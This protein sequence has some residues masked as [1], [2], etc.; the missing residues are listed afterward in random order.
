[1]LLL[2]GSN[3]GLFNGDISTVSNR[4]L[5]RL[6]LTCFYD[7]SLVANSEYCVYQFF[8]NGSSLRTLYDYMRVTN[9]YKTIAQ[10]CTGFS[11]TI[12]VGFG[13]C[14]PL[15]FELFD[16][17]ILCIC[18]TDMCNKNF[19]S[20]QSSV[21]NQLQINSAPSV[22]SS[23]V[24]ELNTPIS[25]Y[26]SSDS[27]NTSFYCANVASPYIDIQKCNE[28]TMNNTANGTTTPI[29]TGDSVRKNPNNIIV[30]LWLYL[31]I[32]LFSLLNLA[33]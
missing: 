3:E 28:Y 4:T 14:S 25:C 8:S 22:L 17:S 2:I 26:D 10:R 12:D 16:I 30:F 21:T 9:I 5:N 32:K 23:M 6:N 20:C 24:P 15:E 19:T 1:M 27:L 7:D 11:N 31:I 33:I 13:F 29:P 18:A